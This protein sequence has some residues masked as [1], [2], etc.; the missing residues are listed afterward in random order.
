M[1]YASSV[2]PPSQVPG[3]P[4]SGDFGYSGWSGSQILL[5]IKL[6]PSGVKV[7]S[8]T[9]RTKRRNRYR[10]RTAFSSGHVVVSVRSV[11]RF[12]LPI[13]LG[14]QVLVGEVGTAN[15]PVLPSSN[16]LRFCKPAYRHRDHWV[17][18]PIPFDWRREEFTHPQVFTLLHHHEFPGFLFPILS[19][20]TNVILI[21]VLRRVQYLVTW[22]K[23]VWAVA[24]PLVGRQTVK[25]ELRK[26]KTVFIRTLLN[27]YLATLCRADE[28]VL[29]GLLA[30]LQAEKLCS[31][32]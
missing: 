31:V 9:H 23:I 2:R 29:S 8:S 24:L 22:S 14:P 15:L 12:L 20:K 18:K 13:V 5:V 28:A 19:T 25:N 11:G 6:N 21:L 1:V 10:F 16:P 27:L 32:I 3:R 7:S 17:R 30:P 4:D 26:R